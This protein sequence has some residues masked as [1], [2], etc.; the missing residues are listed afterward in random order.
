MFRVVQHWSIHELCFRR[1]TFPQ[2]FLV[3]TQNER[4]RATNSVGFEFVRNQTIRALVAQ[5]GRKTGEL[6]R[7]RKNFTSESGHADRLGEI[8]M[9]TPKKGGQEKPAQSEISICSRGQRAAAQRSEEGEKDEWAA[10]QAGDL[11][12]G[13]QTR[14]LPVSMCREM[15]WVLE[16]PPMEKERV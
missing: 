2:L 4:T 8:A 13:N 16:P 1:I 9:R 11:H 7:Q 10:E 5:L 6:S 12:E 3:A 14:S 15:V